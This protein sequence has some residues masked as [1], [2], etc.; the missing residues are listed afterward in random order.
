MHKI[1]EP[2]TIS[3]SKSKI[4][5]TGKYILGALLTA[6]IAGAVLKIFVNVFELGWSL[7]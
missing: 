1:N 4:L 5:Q 3:I 6:F 7:F 2:E